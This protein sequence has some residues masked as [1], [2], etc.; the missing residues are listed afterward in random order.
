MS[1]SERRIV[2]ATAADQPDITTSDGLYAEALKRHGFTVVGAPWNGPRAAFDGAAAVVIRSTWGYYRASRRLPRL[3]R[4]D[5]RR[6]PPLQSDR[7]GAL[8]P[9]QGLYRQAR[10]GSVRVPQTRFVACEAEAIEKVFAETGWS[11]A[12]VKPA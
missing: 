4:G 2:L 10:G 11:R 1:A 9:A 8:E 12:V 7:A 5:G 3:D 6:D